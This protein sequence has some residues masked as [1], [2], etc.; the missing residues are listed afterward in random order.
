MRHCDGRRCQFVLIVR[1]DFFTSHTRLMQHLELPLAEGTNSFAT[2]PF[3]VPH[4]RRVLEA[5]G[6]AY[7]RFDGSEEQ[8]KFVKTV[9]EQLVAEDVGTVPIRLT[10]LAETLRE[11]DWTQATLDEFGGVDG[12]ATRYLKTRMDRIHTETTAA[13][14]P[15]AF[16]RLLHQLLPSVG[17]ESTLPSKT[18]DELKQACSWSGTDSDFSNL[19]GQLEQDLQLIASSDTTAADKSYRLAHGFLVRPL[20]DNLQQNKM[21]TVRGR[22]ELRLEDRVRLWSRTKDS[23]SLPGSLEYLSF[24]AFT[25]RS[26]W[27]LATTTMMQ[28]TR[29]HLA[30]RW[31]WIAGA[32]ASLCLVAAFFGYSMRAENARLRKEKLRSDLEAVLTSSPHWAQDTTDRF[33]ESTTKQERQGLIAEVDTPSALAK[34]RVKQLRARDGNV[35]VQSLVESTIQL[36][37]EQFALT[38]NEIH[39]DEFG[40]IIAAL[41][42]HTSPEEI[43]EV[44]T[45]EFEANTNRDNKEYTAKERSRRQARLAIL[46]MH[47]GQPKLIEQVCSRNAVPGTNEQFINQSRF[48]RDDFGVVLD[49]IE[50]TNRTDLKALMINSLAVY[51]QDHVADDLRTRAVRILNRVVEEHTHVAATAAAVKTLERWGE[52]A[53]HALIARAPECEVNAAKVTMVKCQSLLP[54]QK[55]KIRG[56]QSDL[57][58]GQTEITNQQFMRFIAS[59]AERPKHWLDRA[60]ELKE[61]SRS[62]PNSPFE[63]ASLIDAML[64]CNWLSLK[65]ELDPVYDVPSQAMLGRIRINNGNNG[66]RLP[67]NEEWKR[68]SKVCATF[69]KPM[70]FF[71]TSSENSRETLKSVRRKLPNP[72]GLFDTYGSVREWTV[73]P[74]SSWKYSKLKFAQLWGGSYN[75]PRTTFRVPLDFRRN[76]G[77]EDGELGQDERRRNL[78]A[79]LNHMIG[80]GFRVVRNGSPL[81]EPQRSE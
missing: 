79:A 42:R 67:T 28:A 44:L 10:A 15:D 18:A 7:G 1:D 30:P 4:T 23:E 16:R 49:L 13:K 64:Y 40:S 71:A 59:K 66:Y 3:D 25:R 29:R 8:T 75:S 17:D 56:H 19:L 27:N 74:G 50:S 32:V 47:L 12:V 5:Y 60:T 37:E 69:P 72:N 24:R 73:N 26:D 11:S 21:E 34:L 41:K 78:N 39:S 43:R 31:A 53:P 9:A 2:T 65:C 62:Q 77:I 55:I 14:H 61:V 35:D 80:S 36:S 22:A 46:G 54:M 48:F 63:H 20:R 76:Q 45:A 57:W 68:V 58:V 33:F 51:P 6:R 52:P 70:V 81:T 38:T